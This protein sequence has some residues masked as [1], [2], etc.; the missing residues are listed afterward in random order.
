M[1]KSTSFYIYDVLI[2]NIM[3]DL[4]WSKKNL[5]QHD[6]KDCTTL[7]PQNQ[8]K[9][10]DLNPILGYRT[11]LI[12]IK[13]S[14]SKKIYSPSKP[15]SKPKCSTVRWMS[16]CKARGILKEKSSVNTFKCN[17][18]LRRG[19]LYGRVMLSSPLVYNV[20]VSWSMFKPSWSSLPKSIKKMMVF[21][22]S[23]V[24]CCLLW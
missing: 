4:Y 10:S 2:L 7:T 1:K 8:L 6:S 24:C 3:S 22:L 12:L 17:F 21:N 18:E 14:T 13:M 15:I 19:I 9:I 20:S 11:S 23:P 5:L 16:R